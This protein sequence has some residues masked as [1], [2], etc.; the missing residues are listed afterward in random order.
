M[1]RYQNVLRKQV[2]RDP[3]FALY[4]V[5]LRSALPNSR[6]TAKITEFKENGSFF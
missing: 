3:A 1:S 2:F 6:K 5:K 4:L